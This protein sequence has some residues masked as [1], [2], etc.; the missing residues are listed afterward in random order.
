MGHRV[1]VSTPSYHGDRSDGSS[2][3]GGSS[4][5][6]P[7]VNRNRAATLALL[8]TV[9]STTQSA[10]SIGS[11]RECGFGT[12]SRQRYCFPLAQ[13]GNGRNNLT[14]LRKHTS[15]V[16][17]VPPPNSRLGRFQQKSSTLKPGTKPPK[18]KHR[19]DLRATA[20]HCIRTQS[21]FS[22]HALK[23][24]SVYD[25]LDDSAMSKLNEDEVNSLTA[26][27]NHTDNKYHRA[28][29][30]RKRAWLQ[31]FL[32][33]RVSSISPL[34]DTNSSTSTRRKEYEQ[35]KSAWAAKYS[36]VSAL[37][38]S[39][40]TNK[41]RLWGDLNQSS[42]RRLYH[43]L[44]HGT[45]VFFV[46]LERELRDGLLS[47]ENN[48]TSVTEWRSKRRRKEEEE[49]DEVYLQQELKSLAPLAYQARLAAKKYAR[50]RSR[51]PGRIRSM[52]YDWRR[53]G[54]SSGMTWEQ[55]WS[56][57]EDQVLQEELEMDSNA[58][59]LNE[60]HGK[61]DSLD[62][63]PVLKNKLNETLS[64]DELT[65]RICLRILE[66][67]VV[68]N[69][70]IDKLFLKRL[71]EEGKDEASSINEETNEHRREERRNQR[72]LR[73]QADLRKIELEFD[74]DIQ[75]LLR[76]GN[77]ISREGEKRSEKT[78][79]FWNSTDTPTT[80]SSDVDEGDEQPTSTTKS[81]R[82]GEAE[83]TPE[84]EL[85]SVLSMPE[86]PL[87]ENTSDKDTAA[88]NRPRTLSVHEV[89]ALRILTST[90]QRMKMLQS[91][92]GESDK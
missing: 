88:P 60:F 37:R 47:S 85:A 91:A 87:N 13:L 57:Y 77:L 64:E 48:V 45:V 43:T 56:K 63:R 67:S 61:N 51:L 58:N 36:S 76:H 26:H 42:T 73:I 40:G 20:A 59:V 38:K 25:Q 24:D 6:T 50:E 7:S 92:S 54:K 33:K 15:A 52:L 21:E 89:F 82:G 49:I 72:R 30:G 65:A 17:S 5:S 4:I 34:S 3:I 12:P 2:Y 75:E 83:C 39:F 78:G 71:S 23:E 35:R 32:N 74:Q 53:Y 86:L 1:S 81:A 80:T 18:R 10:V 16:A 79:F 55:V 69:T 70:A 31:R 44:T 27:G 19:S 11:S 14:C 9:A 68:T 90:K 28:S 29:R 62:I 22:L 46:R 84:T 66:R 41:N 8:L